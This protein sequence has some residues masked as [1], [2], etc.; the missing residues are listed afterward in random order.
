MSLV[1]T[2]ESQIFQQTLHKT[3]IK[4]PVESNHSLSTE[5]GPAQRKRP[6]VT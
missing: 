3:L 6:I 4:G 2:V 1:R 5:S